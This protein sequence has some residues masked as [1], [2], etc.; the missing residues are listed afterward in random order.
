[1][2]RRAFASEALALLVVA[3]DDE[4][5]LEGTVREVRAAALAQASRVETIIVDDG[6]RDATAGCAERLAAELPGTVVLRNLRHLGV[7]RAVLSAAA[8]SRSGLMLYVPGDGRFDPARLPELL[9]ASRRGQVVAGLESKAARKSLP[10]RFW[11]WLASGLGAGD[12]DGVGWTY[13][14]RR[15]VF[16]GLT[17][18]CASEA[19]F[20]E[21]AARAGRRGMRVV[22]VACPPRP[23]CV[24]HG[25]GLAGGLRAL[26]ELAR[27][28]GRLRQEDSLEPMERV[29]LD[30]SPLHGFWWPGRDHGRERSGPVSGVRPRLERL[31]IEAGLRPPWLD[32]DGDLLLP[33]GP[34]LELPP[35]GSEILA[36]VG[37]RPA[38]VRE[39]GRVRFLFDA[40]LS[41]RLRLQEAYA[42]LP[43]P[44]ASA[45]ARL[46]ARLPS[47]SLEAIAAA[48]RVPPAGCVCWP[49]DP[50]VEW[51]R[52]AMLHA[53]GSQGE[54]RPPVAPWPHGK[55]WA[56][57]VTHGLAPG[58]EETSVRAASDVDLR[59]G[60]RSCWYVAAGLL[61]SRPELPPSLR[62][63][64]WEVGLLATDSE[65][66]ASGGGLAG[67]ARWLAGCHE[68]VDL[69][70]LTGLRVAALARP[71]P[72]P[73]SVSRAFEYDCSVPDVEVATLTAPL[74]GS[75]TIFPFTSA[76]G[77][78]SLPITL[79]T[80]RRLAILGHPARDALGIW[81]EKV[82]FIR[83]VGG[84]AL[85]A[86]DLEP[87]LGGS[88]DWLSVMAELLEPLLSASDVWLATPAEVARWWGRR[89]G[90][91]KASGG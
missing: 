78:L 32:A 23:G 66:H 90:A 82:E 55:S 19:F 13:L 22:S 53:S 43:G 34:A 59:L 88:S 74:L 54:D 41:A 83:R 11:R 89:G 28:W 75:G 68:L 69:H 60:I 62:E 9:E 30:A 72:I 58:R 47:T 65:L 31:T 1:M 56:L 3:R 84:L 67:A 57:V 39:G 27:L 87:R 91:R 71:A 42:G 70:R 24:R 15:E 50:A 8:R 37:D 36:S 86:T 45:L 85:L 61:R 33:V 14:W 20:L 49:A 51:L 80:P 6:S 29:N 79:P 63:H 40:E 7:G 38:V 2:K 10:A 35:I 76:S 18:C 44:L 21:A 17:A 5:T 81:R 77:A 64:G 4:G 26:L 73:A 25:A 12:G 48:F 16:E 52:W 46:A